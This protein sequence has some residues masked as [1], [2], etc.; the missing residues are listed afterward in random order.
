MKQIN[1]PAFLALFGYTTVDD[2]WLSADC[3]IDESGISA[4]H[5]DNN[6]IE[7]RMYAQS[8]PLDFPCT[9][10]QFFA[11][12][13]RQDTWEMNNIK[14]QSHVVKKLPKEFVERWQPDYDFLTKWYCNVV[15]MEAAIKRQIGTA[16]FD[17]DWPHWLALQSRDAKEA[18]LLA[19]GLE[20]EK[21]HQVM[22][23]ADFQ[24]MCEPVNKLLK[25]TP[26]N[27]AIPLDWL[28]WFNENGYLDYAPRHLLDGFAKFQAKSMEINNISNAYKSKTLTREEISHT[29]EFVHNNEFIDWDYWADL[30][31]ITP[32]QAARLAK[33]INPIKWPDYK[34]YQGDLPDDLRHEIALLTQWLESRAQLWTLVDLVAALGEDAA[35]FDM[36]QAIKDKQKAGIIGNE[37]A[38]E[39]LN[40]HLNH[41]NIAELW[42]TTGEQRS[43]LVYEERI[44]QISQA[45]A[46]GNLVAEVSVR[47]PKAIGGF[48][49]IPY[50][51]TTLS[52]V[53]D[54]FINGTFLMFTIHRDDFR[55]WLIKSNQ[56]PLA[57]GCLLA[58]WFDSETQAEPVTD[59]GGGSQEDTEPASTKAI[60]AN[61]ND[62]DF[63]GLLNEPSKKDA[64]FEVLDAMTKFFYTKFGKV[65]NAT[66]A[67]GQLS[68]V[69]LEGYVITNGTDKGEDCLNMPGEKLLGRVLN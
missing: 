59:A 18:A 41:F 30:T 11:W 5:I 7:E 48:E 3:I 32:T 42:A 6:S 34:Y 10:R 44:S 43:N 23:H 60:K 40:K 14:H 53:R 16:P 58:E 35:P 57:D 52:Q 56:W 31:N 50:S 28:T 64:W 29:S 38:T 68:T 51:Q 17:V 61:S 39:A 21:F 67:W 66:Q 2:C 26:D 62:L 13:Q 69:G 45:V 1:L 12:A 19:L 47:N 49:V 55:E 63:S 20:P 22:S 54:G 46:D 24:N 8:V 27:L 4:K 37:Q 36:I 9:V 25:R 65:P 15:R 33:H